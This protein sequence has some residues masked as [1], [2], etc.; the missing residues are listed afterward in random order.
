MSESCAAVAHAD[1]RSGTAIRARFPVDSALGGVPDFD[2]LS[3]TL[4]SG[5]GC[6]FW[7]RL[8]PEFANFLGKTTIWTPPDVAGQATSRFVISRS[9]VRVRSPA[10]IKS[11]TYEDQ[12]S[13]RPTPCHHCV[14]TTRPWIRLATPT[15]RRSINSSRPDR[16]LDPRPAV[17]TAGQVR[18]RPAKSR[19]SEGVRHEPT[20]V[21]GGPA[22]K[23]L[24]SSDGHA[25]SDAALGGPHHRVLPSD[26][27]TGRRLHRE[28]HVRH[29]QAAFTVPCVW[30]APPAWAPRP[31]LHPAVRAP[32][33]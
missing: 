9:A 13:N 32:T 18:N 28:R 22:G 2:T 4:R 29:P 30:G 14:T 8:D 20:A 17:T 6:D 5:R 15:L 10:P 1:L 19:Q 12:G 31:W 33:R 16:V 23:T 21:P 25:R 24:S 26:P 7:T 11:T 3:D 27:R